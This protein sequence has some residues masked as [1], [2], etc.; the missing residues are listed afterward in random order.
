VL[1]IDKKVEREIVN[2]RA[3]VHPNIVRFR[4]V[5]RHALASFKGRRPSNCIQSLII[6]GL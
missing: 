2:H 4:E 1:Q 6:C 5:A 3:L